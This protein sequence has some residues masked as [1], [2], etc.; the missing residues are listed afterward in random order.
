MFCVTVSAGIRLKAWKMK[1]MRSRLR[2]VRRLSLS[3]VRS[4]PAKLTLPDVGRSSPAAIC[5]NVLLPDPEGPM[6]AVKVPR[7]SPTSIPSSA[8][9]VPSP[10][11]YTL[12]TSCRETTG[13]LPTLCV[14][15]CPTS[16]TNPASALILTP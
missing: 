5:R 4:V 14:S 15:S 1:P 9:I 7:A 6:I 3:R 10:W 8:A 11:P 2:I 16:D 13:T 12:R